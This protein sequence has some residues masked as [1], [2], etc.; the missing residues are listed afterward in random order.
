MQK[1]RTKNS[2]TSP[3]KARNQVVPKR[4]LR[5]HMLKKATRFC[6]HSSLW[7]ICL[8]T[9]TS[10]AEPESTTSTRMVR[11]VKYWASQAQGLSFIQHLETEKKLS[12]QE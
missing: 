10:I 4:Q 6:L 12:E 11:V 7:R 3:K 9:R 1:R 8:N 2:E 5:P